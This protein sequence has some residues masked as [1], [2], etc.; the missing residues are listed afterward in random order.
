MCGKGAEEGQKTL[1]TAERLGGLEG[2]QSRK[3]EAEGRY[4][5]QGG[6]TEG[7]RRPLHACLARAS[8]SPSLSLAAS[9]AC[10]ARAAPLPAQTAGRCL[11]KSGAKARIASRHATRG[12]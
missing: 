10:L 3:G 6:D 11:R 12:T 5:L 9:P 7:T 8:L 4:T 1:L 2:V